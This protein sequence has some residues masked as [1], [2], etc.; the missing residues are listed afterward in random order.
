MGD[1]FLELLLTGIKRLHAAIREY[2][3]RRTDPLGPG[4]NGTR[5]DQW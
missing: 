3:K 4:R 1:R 2:W 5:T